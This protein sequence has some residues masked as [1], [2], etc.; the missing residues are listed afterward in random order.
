MRTNILHGF[1]YAQLPF[2][3]S[4]KAGSYSPAERGVEQ[5]LGLLF[6][7]GFFHK[8]TTRSF[9]DEAFSQ[10]PDLILTP[11]DGGAR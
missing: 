2:L 4:S 9:E 3:G 8:F 11:G 10:L 6:S 5:F 1:F 7:Q